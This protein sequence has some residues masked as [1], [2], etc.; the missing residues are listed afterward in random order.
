MV[1]CF[2]LRALQIGHENRGIGMYL[3]SV[4]EHLPED[5]NKYFFYVFD[6]NDPV[7]E[8]GL[9]VSIDYA[10]VTTKTIKTTVDKPSD[11]LRLLHL[12]TH[13]FNS[14]KGLKPDVFV[15][16]DFMLGIPRWRSVKKI[17]IAYDLIPLIKKN[18]Y[19]PNPVFAWQHTAGKRSKIKAILRSLYYLGRY[20]VHYKVFK[21]ADKILAISEATKKS[22]IERLGI[23]ASKITAIPLAAVLPHDKPKFTQASKIK[24]PYILYVGGT[25]SR[26]KVEDIIHAFQIARGRGADIDL[27]LAGNEFTSLETLPSI[28]ARNTIINSPYKRDI[29]FVGFIQDAEKLGLY[30]RALAFVFC[31]TFE[32][33]GMPIIEAMSAG[34]P[35][36]SYDNSSIPEAAGNA[37]L[38]VESGDYVA[39]AREILDVYH[40]P[41]EK[42]DL[43]KLAV[44]QANKFSWDKYISSFTEVLQNYH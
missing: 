22:F 11:L 27:V 44:K 42:T 24:R 4:L 15:Q 28:I 34:C 33:F 18:Q 20:K 29:H 25:D 31:S 41:N 5:D 23:P 37:A 1:I 35:V 13:R 16:F 12:V 38:L 21:R 43:K 26:K 6:K 3:K 30:K 39:I 19:L 40:N 10:L 9:R 36:I 14:V 17:V 2:D 8:L 32:G 7:K